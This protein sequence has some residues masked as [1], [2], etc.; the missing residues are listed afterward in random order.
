MACWTYEP[1]YKTE[2]VFGSNF[3]AGALAPPLGAGSSP[4]LARPASSL[5]LG[6]RSV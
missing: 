1:L 4:S 5:A 3:V 2:Y 6:W